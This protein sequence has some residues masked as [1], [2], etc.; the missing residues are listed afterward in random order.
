MGQ[1]AA[2]NGFL[3][4]LVVAFTLFNIKLPVVVSGQATC[5]TYD[6]PQIYTVQIKRYELLSKTGFIC[7]FSVIPEIFHRNIQWTRIVTSTVR[8]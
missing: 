8:A 2:K 6:V 3:H 4:W 1:K 7:I 5:R